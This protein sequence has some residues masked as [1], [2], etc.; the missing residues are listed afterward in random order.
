MLAIE[1]LPCMCIWLQNSFPCNLL[2]GQ[3]SCVYAFKQA[4]DVTWTLKLVIVP[5]ETQLG[6]N[7]GGQQ[8]SSKGG[9]RNACSSDASYSKGESSSG[10]PEALQALPPLQQQQWETTCVQ[11]PP[12]EPAC[13]QTSGPQLDH[14]FLCP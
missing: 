10:R 14:G 1:K 5:A 7:G 3:H 6:D 9:K 8:C 13:D 11:V 4:Y 2:G 12:K